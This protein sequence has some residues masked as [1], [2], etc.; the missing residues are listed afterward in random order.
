LNALQF[1]PDP[2]DLLFI[3]RGVIM[4]RRDSAFAVICRR[5]Q[6]LLVKPRGCD[7]WQLP[8]GG[9]KPRETPWVAVLRE[10]KEETGLEARLL[11]L[12]G[13]YRRSDGTLAFVFAARVG[14]Q[15]VPKGHLHEISKRRWMPIRKALRRL[16]RTS[17]E[18]LLD[19]LSRP[20]LFRA[21]ASEGFRPAPVAR[22]ERLALRFSAG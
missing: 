15:K 7:H 13:M 20:S 18:R 4:A 11:A 5:K 19:A 1:H 9:M 14:W 6:V 12:T 17:G 22:L 21:N 8:G 2:A 3:R 16:P 10:V